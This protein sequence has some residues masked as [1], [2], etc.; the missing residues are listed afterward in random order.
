MAGAKRTA[1]R[2]LDR[3]VFVHTLLGNDFKARAFKNAAGPL[4]SLEGDL[5][6]LLQSGE[7][8]RKRGFGREVMWAWTCVGP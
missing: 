7:L 3:L 6:E 4:R 8:A 5:A 2:L 1:A